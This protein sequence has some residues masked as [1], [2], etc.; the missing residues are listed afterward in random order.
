M[1]SIVGEVTGAYKS[2]SESVTERVGNI[3]VTGSAEAKIK[4]H[5]FMVGVRLTPKVANPKV[6]PEHYC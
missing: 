5:T 2:E 1:V 6:A 4:L 3:T